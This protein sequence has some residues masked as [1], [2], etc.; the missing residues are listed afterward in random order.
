MKVL[1]RQNDILISSQLE[2]FY[3]DNW[4]ID[5]HRIFKVNRILEILK[6][7]YLI[8]QLGKVRS[9][10]KARELVGGISDSGLNLWA[11]KFHFSGLSLLFPLTAF[12]G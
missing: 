1:C 2:I 8:L 4:I 6:S 3:L 12:S 7:K 11:S 9:G 5:N 10:D